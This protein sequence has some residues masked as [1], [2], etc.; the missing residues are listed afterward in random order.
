MSLLS[1]LGIVAL[2]VL[3]GGPSEGP[4]IPSEAATVERS[5][6]DGVAGDGPWSRLT[7][8]E[9]AWVEEVAGGLTL[10]EKA[11]Q[12][13]VAWLDGGRPRPESRRWARAMEL[14]EA[15]V[16]G[17]IVGAGPG[18]ETAS[19]LAEL[20]AAAAVPLLVAA[21]LEWGPGT[22][23]RGATL[24]PVN[25]AIAA[26]GGP[27]L[28]YEA[29]RITALEARA[30]GVHMA[31]APVADVNV[32][33]LNPVINTRSYGSDPAA[34][35][36]R[37][38]AFV[39]GARA[40][41]LLTVAKHF[42]GHGDTELDS[43]LTLPVLDV[44]RLRL[45]RV[46]LRPFQAAIG[47]GVDGVMT[48]HLAVSALDPAG[49]RPATLS[50][51]ILTELLRWEL[52][53]GGLVVTDGLHMDGVT[54]SGDAGEV[55]VAALTA[56]ADILLIPPD[57]GAAVAAVVEAVRRGELSETRIDASV[58]RVL[59]AKAASGLSG[60]G[61]P[62][63]PRLGTPMGRADHELWSRWV[64]D[65]SIT[66]PRSAPGALPLRLPGP[67]LLVVYDDRWGHHTGEPLEDE[68][69]ARGA[70]LR[71]VRLSRDSD[72]A[73]LDWVRWL[74]SRTDAVFA[75]F[76]RAVPWRGELGLPEGVARLAADLAD[77][78]APV[79]SFGDPYLLRQLP[80]APTYLLAWSRT[81]TS[82]R[83]A[84][85]ALA[86]AIPIT[87]RL[88]IDLPPDHRV[89]DGLVVPLMPFRSPAPAGPKR[90]ATSVR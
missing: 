61:P 80:D 58:R 26:A 19:W 6:S 79:L 35:A 18:H 74:A 75:S 84:A 49:P 44:P 24:L 62:P 52:G 65:R 10:E 14:V 34:V 22:R 71:T 3:V 11:G 30:A 28:A 53:F 67:L 37:V 20:Q 43:H 42:P 69:A 51:P 2:A 29:G 70:W 60:S 9:R 12:L 76:S 15:G 66:L 82:Q 73:V 7:A 23:L 68:L 36:D 8:A 33:P 1:A 54:A 32:N 50:P 39:A 77:A 59:A 78:G 5:A 45:E 63:L 86:G 40:G 25:M 87:G 88:P 89:G 46:E 56:G 4:W 72:P 47:A 81:D 64:T 31:L 90:G 48:A 57:E 41:G 13:V 38:A 21:D 83:S 17:F 55:A 85:R 27:A 16:G